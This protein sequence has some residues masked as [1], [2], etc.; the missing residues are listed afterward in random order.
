[1]KTQISDKI[2]FFVNCVATNKLENRKKNHPSICAVEISP[3]WVVIAPRNPTGS[4]LLAP[5]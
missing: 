2:N 3:P 1:M 4:L 5:A